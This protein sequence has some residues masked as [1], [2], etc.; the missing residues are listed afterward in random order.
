[1]EAAA[2]LVSGQEEQQLLNGGKLIQ[3]LQE[4]DKKINFLESKILQLKQ[5]GEALK[6]L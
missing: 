3:Q 4:K 6:V 1:M 2:R 5:V